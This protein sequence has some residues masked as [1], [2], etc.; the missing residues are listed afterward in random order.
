MCCQATRGF[1]HNHRKI[2]F[3]LKALKG[4]AEVGPVKLSSFLFISPFS[5]PNSLR[6]F[7]PVKLNFK[8][9]NRGKARGTWK[10]MD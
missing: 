10:D 1:G 6:G 4:L 2:I 9:R 5:F 7:L 8:S 3:S